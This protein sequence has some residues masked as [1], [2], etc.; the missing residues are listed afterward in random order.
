MLLSIWEPFDLPESIAEMIK[1][2][3]TSKTVYG[4]TLLDSAGAYC[5]DACVEP[6][7]WVHAPG[8]FILQY[9]YKP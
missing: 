9:Y 6:H 7:G 5:P 4:Y 1:T 3:F 8:L 2:S